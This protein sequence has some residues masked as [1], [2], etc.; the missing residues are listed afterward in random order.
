VNAMQGFVAL[1]GKE[2]RALFVQPIAY[3]LV[4]VFL[5][6]MGY[7]FVTNLALTRSAALVRIVF[8]AAT[9]LLLFIPLVTM[10]M[11]AEERRH[12]TLELLLATPVR[13]PA[14][15]LAKYAATMMLVF[16][17][18]VPTFV[19]PLVLA[20]FGQP[21]WG[22]LY[23]GCLGLV[24]LAS[25]L[26]AL[27][28]ALS[29]VTANQVVAATLTLGLALLLWLVDSLAA[30][31]PAPWDELILNCS[32]LAHFTPFA[33]GALHLS[34]AGFFVTATLLGLFLAVRALARR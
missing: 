27:G 16:V 10:R 6:V 8:Q 34:D 21:D 24:L 23:G 2:L 5:F 32:L 12:G 1:L 29:A 14:V 20:Q 19:Y 15:V 3:V 9:L 4:A 18:L 26:T 11:L 13:E 25:L 28:L 7:T 30:V 31:L 17:M 33:T 22:T